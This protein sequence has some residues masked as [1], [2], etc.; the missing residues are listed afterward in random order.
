MRYYLIAGEASGDLH[1]SNLMG[2]LRALDREANMRCWGGEKMEAAGGSLAMHYRQLAF[3]GFA[4]VVA[5]LP[6]ILRNMAFCKTDITAFSPDVLVL[7]D[8]P[9]FNIRIAK[10]AKQHGYKVVYYISPQVWAW[11]ANRVHLLKRCIDLMMV[12]LPFEKAYYEKNWQW[13]VHYVGHPLAAVIANYQPKA[14]AYTRPVVAVLPGSRR[15]EIAAKLP[16]MLKVAAQF[17]DYQFVVAKVPS[18]D[19]A[20][21]ARFL[22]PY[23]NVA[24]VQASTYDLLNTAK[25]AIVTS[26]TATLET[27]L[28]GVPQVVCYKGSAISYHIAKR[29]LTIKYIC[30]VNLLLDKMVVKELIQHEMTA[31]NI[32]TELHLMLHNNDHRQSIVT[33]Y[34]QLK[35]LLLADGDASQNAAQLLWDCAV[36]EAKTDGNN[37]NGKA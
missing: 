25:A 4:E 14:L 37:L 23:T 26:G 22:A 31:G 6:T 7:I 18:I 36:A 29:V 20:F 17:T 9:G 35:T 10:W 19:D 34:A 16:E 30:L 2:A 27:A 33:D 28:F 24:V 32:S 21:Y 5:N 12:I 13:N 11:K 3:M 1:G 15:Q 8:Y